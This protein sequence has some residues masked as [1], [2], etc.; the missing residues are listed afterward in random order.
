MSIDCSKL[1]PQSEL[2]LLAWHRLDPD[3][4]KAGLD[5][6]RGLVQDPTIGSFVM[7]LLRPA[8]RSE[9]DYRCFD[10]KFAEHIGRLPG[11]PREWGIRCCEMWVQVK[12]SAEAEVWKRLTAFVG[13]HANRG[14]DAKAWRRHHLPR[15]Q[16]LSDS[17]SDCKDYCESSAAFPANCHP[18]YRDALAILGQLVKEEDV[19]C[20]LKV[21]WY[22]ASAVVADQWISRHS[23]L[24]LNPCNPCHQGI[25][26]D[27]LDESLADFDPASY[28]I[29]GLARQVDPTAFAVSHMTAFAMNA[30]TEVTQGCYRYE[31]LYRDG[32]LAH[33]YHFGSKGDYFSAVSSATC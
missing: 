17:L 10:A 16:P 13:A 31:K 21:I 27:L 8:G 23:S 14:A 30:V 9:C 19:V 25:L 1:F 29:T 32:C 24:P 7:P 22:R 4:H 5:L 11:R 33:P 6:M 26:V 18:R 20:L 12:D 2:L 3:M 28:G 15:W